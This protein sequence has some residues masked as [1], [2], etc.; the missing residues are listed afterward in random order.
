M[1][2]ETPCPVCGWYNETNDPCIYH[3]EEMVE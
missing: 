2:K 3:P 1:S